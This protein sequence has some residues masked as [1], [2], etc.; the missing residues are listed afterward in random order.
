MKKPPILESGQ[1]ILANTN[2]LNLNSGI[3]HFQENNQ[4]KTQLQPISRQHNNVVGANK[5]YMI[6]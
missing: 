2:M 1:V 4:S 3:H 5:I 6:R